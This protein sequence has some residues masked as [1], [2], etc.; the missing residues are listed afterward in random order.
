M[1]NLDIVKEFVKLLIKE[2]ELEEESLIKLWVDAHPNPE[3][4][5]QQTNYSK[6]K[7]SELKILCRNA[8]L[9]TTGTKAVLIDRLQNPT[10]ETSVVKKSK[11][12]SK[13]K[14][15]KLSDILQ[16][17][18]RDNEIINVRRNLFNNFEHVESALVFDENKIVVGKQDPSGTVLSLTEEDINT[19]IRHNFLYQIPTTIVEPD[20]S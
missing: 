8:G 5:V 9:K 15:P 12:K 10:A 4:V 17:I 2:Y 18:V 13:K 14:Q 11:G 20:E 7:V 3:P 6:K 16:K 19:C 1:S